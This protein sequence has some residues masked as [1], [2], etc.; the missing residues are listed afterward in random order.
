MSKSSE[1]ADWASRRVVV[2]LL[3]LFSALA[4]R[5][6]VDQPDVATFSANGWHGSG[7]LTH[8]VQLNVES[9]K[10]IFDAAQDMVFS[11]H[12]VQPIRKVILEARCTAKSSPTRF[13][14][15]CPY[16]AGT[17]DAS[18]QV[19]FEVVE[20]WGNLTILSADFASEDAIDAIRIG[21]TD[22]GTGNWILTRLAII[23]GEKRAEDDELMRTFAMQL[24]TPENLNLSDLT[25]SSLSLS[26][27]A[28]EDAVGYCFELTKLTG[29]PRTEICEDFVNAPS[30]S[31]GWTY[32]GKTEGLTLSDGGKS[33]SDTATGDE[34]ALKIEKGTNPKEGPVELGL[35]SPISSEPISGWSFV[36]RFGALDKSNSFAVY[37]RETVFSTKWIELAKNLIPDKL[38][39]N[40]LFSGT[41]DATQNIH[42]VWF[43]L[44]ADAGSWTTTG[45][46]SL[47]VVYGGNEERERISAQT[48]AT[49]TATWQ[50]LASGRYGCRV[51]ALG[52]TEGEEQFKDSA[53]SEEQIVDLAWADVRLS[54]PENLTFEVSGDKL[55]LSW[56]PVA[57]TDHYEVKVAPGD[58]P[59]NPVATLVTKSVSASVQLAE[60]GD[61]VVTVTA[62]SPGGVSTA[63]SSLENCTVALGKVTGL[64]VEATAADTIAATW[65]AVP[66]AESYQA[67]LFKVTGEAGTEVSD[68]S[69]LTEG[70]W[71]AGWEHSPNWLPANLTTTGPK[72]TYSGEWIETKS[73]SLGITRVT[74][75]AKSNSS[76]ADK[77]ANQHLQVEAY[78][79]RDGS[80]SVCADVDIVST[81]QTTEELTFEISDDVRRLRFTAFTRDGNYA[82]AIQLGKV[83]VSYGAYVRTEV[84]SVGTK[85]CAATYRGLDRT[86]K[87]VVVVTP[88]PS[89]GTECEASSV[90]V[91]LASEYFRTVGPVSVA[92]CKGGVYLQRFDALAG[93][94]K[95]TDLR[96]VPLESWQF[97]KGSGEAEKLFYTSGTNSTKGGVYC[98]SDAE[99]TT[100]SFMIGTVATSTMG[101]SVGLAFV[102]DTGSSLGAPTLTYT[103]VRRNEKPGDPYVLEWLVTDGSW[104]IG[105]E[106]D[107][108]QP[109]QFAE[110]EPEFSVTPDCRL[111]PGQVIIFRWR[112]EKVSGGPMLGLDDVH[113]EFPVD[114][115]GFGVYVR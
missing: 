94:T 106:S 55:N 49:P 27:S 89:E 32:D 82:P 36:G 75:V 22:S 83:S 63:T 60:L 14:T 53:W 112:H 98:Y 58:N 79:V 18:R 102:N 8:G 115:P 40:K 33:Y 65:N 45:L 91:D 46:D 85:D 114:K 104:S 105:T 26:A 52:A 48:N 59:E 77:L 68:Y 76:S 67:K 30:L 57:R 34:H 39:S 4:A 73:L 42:Q 96:R 9:G 23:Y 24:P 64:A 90:V 20:N 80:W 93:V 108:W 95:E 71:P 61:Y 101:S 109:L 12:Y 2:G 15:V 38:K 100:N 103:A 16:V 13:L 110:G 11:P 43:V 84:A 3:A 81:S 78:S 72:F 6:S 1:K 87:Y 69:N 47:C 7:W 10:P 5:A 111:G 29:S 25:S 17:E 31:H 74:F 54:P 92:K 70:E 88:Q 66:L 51:K 62:V 21:T 97:F 113:V 44:T 99:R 56:S 86:A 50:G 41:V 107:A 28:V 37:G 19:A 35:L